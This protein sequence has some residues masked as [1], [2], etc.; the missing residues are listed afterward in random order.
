MNLRKGQLVV[1]WSWN[2]SNLRIRIYTDSVKD[3]YG[4]TMYRVREAGKTEYECRYDTWYHCIP[5]E[6]A[7]PDVFIGSKEKPRGRRRSIPASKRQ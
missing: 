2:Y 3:A 7:E 5:L 1:V 4:T 6:E